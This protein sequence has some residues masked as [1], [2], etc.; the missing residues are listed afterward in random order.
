MSNNSF[1]HTEIREKG[2]FEMISRLKKRV[3]ETFFSY[4]RLRAMTR[5]NPDMVSQR[6]QFPEDSLNQLVLTTPWEVGSADRPSK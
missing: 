4:C 5:V 2:P 3:V 1:G 6:K